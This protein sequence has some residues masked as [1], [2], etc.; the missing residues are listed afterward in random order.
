[1][2]RSESVI[3]KR[4]HAR[5]SQI[6][7]ATVFVIA[8]AGTGAVTHRAVA[9]EANVPL[10]ATTYYFSSPSSPLFFPLVSAPLSFWSLYYFFVLCP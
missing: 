3:Q 10:A 4:A 7:D 6:I 8:R 2:I 9:K 5:K 1:M